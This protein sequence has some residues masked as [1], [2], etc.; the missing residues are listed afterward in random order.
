[1]DEEAVALGLGQRVG[2][3]VLDRVLG[4]EHEERVGQRVRLAVDGH[5]ALLHRLQQRRLGLRRR[6]VDLVREHEAGEHRAGPEDELAAAQRHRARDVGGQHVRRELQAPELE[7]ERPRDR[8][9]EQGLRGPRDAL[10]QH[11]AAERERAED[12]LQRLVVAD[13]DLAHLARHAGVQLLHGAMLLSSSGFVRASAAASASTYSIRGGGGSVSGSSVGPNRR[14]TDH[15]ATSD[16]RNS[17]SSTHLTCV[18]QPAEAARDAVPVHGLQERHGPPRAAREPQS[19]RRVVG[20]RQPLVLQGGRIG[21][22][23]NRPARRCAR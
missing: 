5:L 10:E 14:P 22:Q 13:H 16:V 8:A 9:R 19:E 2:A 23:R 4:G 18:R 20:E 7:L 1:M 12:V 17:P 6:A 15:S 11:M 21:D 3:L